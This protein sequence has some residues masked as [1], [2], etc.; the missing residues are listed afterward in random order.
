MYIREEV[1][2][3]TDSIVFTVSRMDNFCAFSMCTIPF[4]NWEREGFRVHEIG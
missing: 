2:R 4:L 1:G 3:N